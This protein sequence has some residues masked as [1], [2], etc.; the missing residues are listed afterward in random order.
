MK[1]RS[2]PEN[3]NKIECKKCSFLFE[4]DEIVDVK[5]V[6]YCHECAEI[7]ELLSKIKSFNYNGFI[8]ESSEKPIRAYSLPYSS[9][10]SPINIS[11]FG[12]SLSEFCELLK[13]FEQEITEELQSL[14]LFH[15]KIF[16]IN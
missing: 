15:I 2:T 8:I 7:N 1:D 3:E 16:K 9:G 4:E 6:K 10:D 13:D 12:V 14:F 11:K 5:D